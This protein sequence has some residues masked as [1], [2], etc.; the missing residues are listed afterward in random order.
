MHFLKVVLAED[1]GADFESLSVISVEVVLVVIS[2]AHLSL[3]WLA[4]ELII[5]TGLLRTMILYFNVVLFLLS[6]NFLVAGLGFADFGA[7][8]AD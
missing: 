1:G 8:V 4:E 2:S 6:H 7:D 5:F 3:N